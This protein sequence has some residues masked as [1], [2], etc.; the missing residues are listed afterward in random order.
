MSS[1]DHW[2]TVDVPTW[3]LE[4]NGFE[5]DDFPLVVSNSMKGVII[6]VQLPFDIN[7]NFILP[8]RKKQSSPR[9]SSPRR[10]PK[11]GSRSPKRSTI[12]QRL[13]KM[14]SS[15]RIK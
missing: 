6:R 15:L 7:N 14:M 8:R 3:W 9:R 10:S 2:K 1:I 5:Y 11:K 13:N 4:E 12:R